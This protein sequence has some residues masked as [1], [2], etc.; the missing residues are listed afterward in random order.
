MFFIFERL[1]INIGCQ[2]DILDKYVILATDFC[3]R[4]RCIMK[5]W[6]RLQKITVLTTLIYAFVYISMLI[7]RPGSRHFYD[8][9]FN[10]YQIFPPLFAGIVGVIFY[11]YGQHT[12]AMRRRGWLFIAIAC[13]SFVVG[14]SAWTY[15]ESIR[16]VEVPFP[17]L[18]DIGFLGT[19]IL[20]IPGVLML[21]GSLNVAGRLRQL[22]DSAIVAGSVG[23]LSWSFLV[24]KLWH[25]SDASLIGKIISITY[26]LGDIAALFGA[27]IL[28]SNARQ[29]KDLRRSLNFLAVGILGFVFFDTS[30]TW[31]SMN[32]T[33][34]TGS[35]S[36]WMISF[37]WILIGYSFLTQMWWV[38]KKKTYPNYYE[39]S[40]TTRIPAMWQLA[41]PY[42][43]VTTACLVVGINDY[44]KLASVSSSSVIAGVLLMLL[45][46]IR[47][48]LALIENRSLTLELKSFNENLEKLVAQRTE[49]LELQNKTILAMAEERNRFYRHVSHEV[50][51]P[52]TSVIGFAEI[53]ME[54]TDE[55]LNQW[56]KT[57][58][59]KVVD[60][61]YRL[62]N[63]INDLLDISRIESERMEVRYSSIK[64][65]VVTRQI[66]DNMKP[67][68]QSKALD[69]KMNVATNLPIII[70]DEQK[71]TQIIVNLMSNAIKYTH[72][73]AISIGAVVSSE[74]VSICVE[75]TGIG[76]P[77]GELD[78]IFKEFYRIHNGPVQQ[79]SGLGLAIVK[80]LVDLIGGQI[81]I[82]SKQ[83]VGSTF[84]VTIPVTPHNCC[85]SNSD[86]YK[87]TSSASASLLLQ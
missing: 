43:A 44:I 70:T 86:D 14:Q 83:G 10:T 64:L 4:A 84:T 34:H 77:E 11:R 17:S 74:L 1:S 36:D 13:I 67:L 3:L 69:I 38:S 68:A 45:V 85:K 79:G 61:A 24:Q 2:N 32:N 5:S 78:N 87:K 42:I 48:I 23:V 47:Q 22:L 16:G 54:D 28:I 75:D 52:L 73:G 33:Y 20:L 59:K 21:F 49:E 37:G 9:F 6:T 15:F 56:Q 39:D 41:L 12:N 81:T 50:R 60:G 35:W 71:L 7:A 76:I 27:I 53:L 25:T 30:F 66:A 72:S 63:M 40:P 51:T 80:K 46:M 65:D 58:L 8:A 29:K 18:A 55:P 26:P 82:Q 62:L 19:Y 57:Q 31:M